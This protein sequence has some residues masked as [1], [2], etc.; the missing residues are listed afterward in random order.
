MQVTRRHC[1]FRSRIQLWRCKTAHEQY[2]SSGSEL[3][4]EIPIETAA[5]V[6]I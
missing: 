3:K 4:K 1:G 6:S 5:A 2:N